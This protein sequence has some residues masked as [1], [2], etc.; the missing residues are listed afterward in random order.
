MSHE[1]LESDVA[2]LLG[3]HDRFGQ[4]L[5]IAIV[6]TT[7]LGAVTGLMQI[8]ALRHHDEAID[9]ADQWGALA[10]QVGPRWDAAA[11]LQI[12][13]YRLYVDAR[14]RSEQAR[15]RAFLGVGPPRA[16]LALAAARWDRVATRLQRESASLAVA[17][18]AE[19]A[20]I[21]RT[22][23]AWLPNVRERL[24]AELDPRCPTPRWAAATVP[25]PVRDGPGFAGPG[26]DP[27]F[28]WR[29]L[30]DSRRDAYLIDA[31]R[32]GASRE[33]V[34]AEKQFTEFAVGLT[35]FAVAVFLLGFSLSPYG[36]PHRHLF[37]TT[38]AALVLGA[39]IWSIRAALDAPH[40]PNPQ[41]AVEYADGRVALDRSGPGDIRAAIVYLDCAIAHDPGFAQAYIDRADAYASL[42]NPR[43]PTGSGN[44]ELVPLQ[45]QQ[46]SL[47]DLRT[48][49]KL[50]ADDPTLPGQLGTY[51]FQRGLEQHDAKQMR[52]G[53][54]LEQETARIFPRD[55]V[56][57]FNV[58]EADLALGR[59]WRPAYHRAVLLSGESIDVAAALTDLTD[60]AA[61][62]RG[63]ARLRAQVELAKEYVVDARDP[64]V[65][66]TPVGRIAIDKI[67]VQPG[68]V[69]FILRKGAQ[70]DPHIDTL[71]AEWYYELPGTKVWAG[72]GDISGRTKPGV[73]PER[74][75]FVIKALPRARGT[76]CVPSGLFRLELYANG[77]LAATRIV[78]ARV[79]RLVS[80]PLQDMNVS[81]C[82]KGGWLPLERAARGA[83]PGLAGGYLSSDRRRGILVFDVTPESAA[84]TS[85][86]G[87]VELLV[88]AL[89]QFRPLL[90]TG[91]RHP[92][93][94][95]FP[96]L[97][98]SR[99]SWTIDCLYPGG[100]LYA[101]IGATD[102]G[103]TLVGVVFGPRRMFDDAVDPTTGATLADNLL[104][105]IVTSDPTSQR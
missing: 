10:S 17:L 105:S 68:Y 82:R 67:D 47:A 16:E 24:P 35:V 75:L 85:D 94:F 44:T 69:E 45:Q 62:S 36:T 4:M 22:T 99:R 55:P 30:A 60:V 58:A 14:V 20:T 13:R 101:A 15:A 7:L 38:A 91:L 43:D 84:A 46:R 53:L 8:Q 50:G 31:L 25:P 2:E 66:R 100:E 87:A 92:Q 21:G 93:I 89:R 79:A 33:A 11:R 74:R 49:E 3:E 37:A 63:D 32:T 104:A 39:S 80:S 86:L 52:R 18:R 61:H 29:Y 81:V 103:R 9:R 28:P 1:R 96:F 76:R 65:R 27:Y 90:P 56:Y 83:V 57:A 102:F 71:D 73:D 72:M 26:Q 19:F 88:R 59:D 23:G 64:P 5:V 97:G 34:G 41:A 12:D 51:V 70:V 54:T 98:G 40:A 95:R 48:A 42:P 6:A 77:R 78:S